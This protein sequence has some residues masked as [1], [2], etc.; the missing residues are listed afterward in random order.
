LKS[1]WHRIYAD[2]LAQSRLDEFGQLLAIAIGRGYSHKTL[3]EFH[4]AIQEGGAGAPHR[5]FLHRHDIDTDPGTASR[6]FEIE[7]AHDVRATYYFRLTT[8]DLRLMRAIHDYGG[9]VGYHYEEVASYC[10]SHGIVK[11]DEAW[12]VMPEI[13]RSFAENFKRLEDAFGRKIRS[14]A[15]HGDFANRRLAITNVVLLDSELRRELGIEFEDYDPG[16]RAH[17][18]VTLSDS[19]RPP[20]YR[21]LSPFEAIERGYEV[22]HLLT[23]P[24]HWRTNAWANTVENWRR[25]YEG[26]RWEIA[27]RFNRSGS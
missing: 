19:L 27:C 9:E 10:K 8:V 7:K 24:R 21:D 15:A 18:T 17:Y 6:M 22:I 23:H 13:R 16:V 4:R 5:A 2:Y 25:V 1:V 26:V 14:V 3:I 12:T 11:P 20:G